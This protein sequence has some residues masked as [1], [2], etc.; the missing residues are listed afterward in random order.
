MR[1]AFRHCNS[2]KSRQKLDHNRITRTRLPVK[3]RSSSGSTSSG[4]TSSS[5]QQQGPDKRI[6]LEQLTQ[7]IATEDYASAAALKQQIKELD[8]LNPLYGLTLALEQAVEEERYEVCRLTTL[9]IASSC[10]AQ[11][12]SWTS[13]ANCSPGPF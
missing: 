3:C 6:L 8:L 13:V 5:S 11:L 12:N 10:D 9:V 4:S 2:L 1:L 7:A